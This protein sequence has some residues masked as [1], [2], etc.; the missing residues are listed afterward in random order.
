MAKQNRDINEM[1]PLFE[2]KEEIKIDKSVAIA[3]MEKFWDELKAKGMFK[4]NNSYSEWC[5][6]KKE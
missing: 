6:A 5:G 1:Y 3:S 2:N 4:N